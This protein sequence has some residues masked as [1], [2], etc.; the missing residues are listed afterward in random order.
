MSWEVGDLAV[1]VHFGPWL[2]E[3]GRLSLGPDPRGGGTYVVSAVVT[4][5]DGDLC[6]WLD[7]PFSDSYL[8]EAFKKPDAHKPC[9]EEFV[10]LLKRRKVDA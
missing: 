10:T 7:G 2:E 5:L 1:C 6:L 8:A 3:D 4:D 9:E